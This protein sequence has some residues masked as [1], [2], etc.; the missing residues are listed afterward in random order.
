MYINI[1]TDYILALQYARHFYGFTA[2]THP[3][4]TGAEPELLQNFPDQKAD[5]EQAEGALQKAGLRLDHVRCAT[6]GLTS[7]RTVLTSCPECT[8]PFTPGL[9]KLCTRMTSTN[10]GSQRMGPPHPA[11]ALPVLRGLLAGQCRGLPK[12]QLH[13]CRLIRNGPSVPASV[14]SSVNGPPRSYPAG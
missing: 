12:P 5:T 1:S 13:T 14:S 4:E 6:S 11:N 7:A 10:Q 3:S 8:C 9:Q 2:P